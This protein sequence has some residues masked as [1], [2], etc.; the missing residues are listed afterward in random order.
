MI[1]HIY[2]YLINNN[3]RIEGITIKE[4]D[5]LINHLNQLKDSYPK[6][7]IVK[8]LSKNDVNNIFKNLDIDHEKVNKCLKSAV[9]KRHI[10]IKYKDSLNN[11]IYSSS[12][13]LCGEELNCTIY[14]ILYQSE[15]GGHDYDEGSDDATLICK[16]KD[17]D[18][19]V[20]V[21]G[22]CNNTPEFDCGKFHNHCTNNNCKDFG[23]CMGD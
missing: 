9:L 11:V 14:D 8:K 2:K 13:E 1:L 6:S 16:N 23:S 19:R 4:L 17:C 15:F 22:L 20:Y 10:I 3:H 7:E 5:I 21:T 18:Y 12:C